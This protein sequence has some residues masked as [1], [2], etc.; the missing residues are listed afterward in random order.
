MPSN[1]ILTGSILAALLL[2]AFLVLTV[3]LS[4]ARK[5]IQNHA[6]ACWEYVGDNPHCPVHSAQE[7]NA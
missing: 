6:C 3:M 4:R 5:Q 1:L 7:Q 2:A